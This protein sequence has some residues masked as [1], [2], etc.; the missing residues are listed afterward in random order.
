MLT[1]KQKSVL[2]FIKTEL[3]RN[4]VAPSSREIQEH[5]GFSSQT[6]AMNHLK[7]LARKGAIERLPKRARAVALPR[8]IRNSTIVDVPVYGQIP[9]GMASYAEQENEGFISIDSSS[10]GVRANAQTFALRVR[11]DS[12]IE[13]HITDGD[14][15]I[16][17]QREPR[18]GDIVAALIDGETTL[19]RYILR[20]GKPH[21][22]AENPAYPELIP[23]RELQIQGVMV[24][25]VRKFKR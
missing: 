6:A 4:G 1:P 12:M 3:R 9:A 15:V 20:D 23:A 24:A 19:K 17:E 10:S 21:L 5:F 11:G 13:A 8:L 7:A 22:K 18:N 2:E 25:L 14:T 16:L